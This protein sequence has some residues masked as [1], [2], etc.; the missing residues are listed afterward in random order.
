MIKG[1]TQRS[2]NTAVNELQTGAKN[3]EVRAWVFLLRGEMNRETSRSCLP[4]IKASLWRGLGLD[5]VAGKVP[6]SG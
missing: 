4:T 1:S 6:G 2:P 3:K 5:R